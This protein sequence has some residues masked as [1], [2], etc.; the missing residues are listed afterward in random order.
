MLNVDI[1][2]QMSSNDVIE[3]SDGSGD[4]EA[5]TSKGNEESKIPSSPEQIAR[6]ISPKNGPNP[7]P[8]NSKTKSL[9]ASKEH[10]GQHITSTSIPVTT[11]TT[12]ARDSLDFMKQDSNSRAN[13]PSLLLELKNLVVL[14]AILISVA[15][16]I[17]V[18]VRMDIQLQ[19]FECRQQVV[20]FYMLDED[21]PRDQFYLEELQEQARFWKNEAK[22]REAQI[23]A[24]QTEYL[25]CFETET[26]DY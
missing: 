7:N 8:E 2:N 14:V 15:S 9:S 6:E 4:L 13:K 21:R 20:N 5:F 11:D 10:A 19:V 3:R 26:K 25:K 17:W 22:Q 24:Y 1:S 12:T 18:N 16:A 23:D